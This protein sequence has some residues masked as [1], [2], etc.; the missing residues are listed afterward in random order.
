MT[1]LDHDN[2]GY[3]GTPGETVTMTITA[4]GTNFMVTY[5]LRGVG[6]VPFPSNGPLQ[7]QLQPGDNTLIL[8]MGTNTSAGSY[9]VVVQ[10]VQNEA[11]HECVHEWDLFGEETEKDFVFSA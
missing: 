7:F 8:V 2:L 9:K 1:D 10:T 11:N 4:T 5:D 6:H 3:Q